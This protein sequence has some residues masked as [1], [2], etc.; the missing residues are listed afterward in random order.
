M[1]GAG[2]LKGMRSRFFGAS[3]E[4]LVETNCSQAVGLSGRESM[5]TMALDAAQPFD[6]ESTFCK[7]IVHRALAEL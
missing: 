6:F 4:Q 5:K 2:I 7:G 3:T 1:R